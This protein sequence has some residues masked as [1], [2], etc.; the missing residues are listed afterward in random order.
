MCVL[1]DAVCCQQ[2]SPPRPG[3]TGVADEKKSGELLLCESAVR[4]DS[5][6]NLKR[7]EDRVGF[8]RLRREAHPSPW[9][10]RI[11]IKHNTELRVQA[12]L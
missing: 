2:Q 5:R 7:E 11:Q 4:V 6:Q 3:H 10:Q 9:E 8:E 12:G 1:V